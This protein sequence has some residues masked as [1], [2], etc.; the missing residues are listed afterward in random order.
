VTLQARIDGLV[1]AADE[2]MYNAKRAG[3]NSFRHAS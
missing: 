1:L 2:A 3:G